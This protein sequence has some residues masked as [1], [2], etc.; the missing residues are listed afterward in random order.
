MPRCQRLIW[1][2]PSLMVASVEISTVTSFTMPVTAWFQSP[3]MPITFA[4][5]LPFL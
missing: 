1:L 4:A 2:V 3:T 5:E